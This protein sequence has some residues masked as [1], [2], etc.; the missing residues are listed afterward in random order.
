MTA[1]P[2]AAGVLEM[3][4]KHEKRIGYLEKQILKANAKIKRLEDEIERL[5]SYTRPSPWDDADPFGYMMGFE[6]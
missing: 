6:D 5:K 2:L 4:K 1:E 3:C